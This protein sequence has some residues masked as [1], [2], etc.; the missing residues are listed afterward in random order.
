LRGLG[1][2]CPRRWELGSGFPLVQV[3]RASPV[4]SG[5]AVGMDGAPSLIVVRNLTEEKIEGS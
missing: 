4:L 5:R 2:T 3:D 1:A